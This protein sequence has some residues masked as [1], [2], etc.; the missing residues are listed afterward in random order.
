M[1]EKKINTIAVS[2]ADEPKNAE[3]NQELKEQQK[4]VATGGYSERYGGGYCAD[5]Y[6]APEIRDAANYLSDDMKQKAKEIGI[7]LT[8]KRGYLNFGAGIQIH[9]PDYVIT[10]PTAFEWK[11]DYNN[12]EITAFSRDC[13]EDI[14][15]SPLVLEIERVKLVKPMTEQEL[16]QRQ[17]NAAELIGGIF[18]TVKLDRAKAVVITDKIDDTKI[19]KRI[20]VLLSGGNEIFKL[21]LTF[22]KEIDNIDEITKRIYFSLYFS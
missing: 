7:E 11:K 22:A 3:Q 8:Q 17:K 19:L 12:R 15:S 10:V 5:S 1:S 16:E 20:F 9:M 18:E 14:F 6:V 4:H 13:S 21:T 2:A